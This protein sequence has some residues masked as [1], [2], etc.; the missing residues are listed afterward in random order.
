MK[1]V[2]ETWKTGDK[3]LE[4]I[5][6]LGDRL[7]REVTS[8]HPDPTA[9]AQIVSRIEHTN[10]L[11]T[12]LE[13]DFSEILGEAARWLTHL[14]LSLLSLLALLVIAIGNLSCIWLFR[15]VVASEA[16]Y[17][18]LMETASVS[19]FLLDNDSGD[20]LEANQMAEKLMRVPAEE[21]RGKPL[22]LRSLETHEPISVAGSQIPIQNVDRELLLPDGTAIP[23]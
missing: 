12:P 10:N 15:K 3:Y 4:T 5:T 11:L 6:R 23:I 8:S 20:V 7:H 19:I 21:L 22:R 18:R 14:L 13:E 16:K 2:V 9:I 17:R 1:K